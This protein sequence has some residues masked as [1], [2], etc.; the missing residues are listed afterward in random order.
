MA[1]KKKK[2]KLKWKNLI[3]LLI[4]LIAFIFLIK[5]GI[6]LINYFID[7]NNTNEEIKSIEDVVKIEEIPDSDNTEI[8]EQKED[9]PE[10]NPYWDYIKMNML[11]VNFS[12]LKKK[13][14]DTIGWIKLEGTNVNYPVVQGTDNSYYLN[15]SFDKSYNK[16]GWV[17]MDYRND[18]ETLNKNTIIYA[19]AR[20]D[21]TMFGTLKKVLNEEWHENK[22]NHIIKFST[23]TKNYLWQIFSVYETK[24]ESYYLTTKFSSDNDFNNFIN[25]LKERSIF[26]FS[27]TPKI[28]DKIIT[29]STCKD[30]KGNR[31]VVHAIL[32]KMETK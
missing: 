27:A 2:Y 15:H 24:K 20:V 26:N 19:H 22:S 28:N 8:I 7:T 11:D 29:L 32:I 3:A 17:F 30:S 16:A 13:N 31:I 18:Y 5:S 1:K 10:D 21:G 9:I 14:K 25:A 23:I 6:D 4:F 12:E